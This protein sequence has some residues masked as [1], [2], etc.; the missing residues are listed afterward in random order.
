MFVESFQGQYKD[1]T[2]GTCDFRMVSA[3]FLILRMLILAS[4]LPHH[5]IDEHPSIKGQCILFMTATGFYAI[6]K[7]YKSNLRNIADILILVLLAIA[8]LILLDATHNS[9]NIN[10]FTASVLLT[11]LL[12]GVPHMVLMFYICYML[13]KKAGITQ[14]LQKKHISLKRCL[15]A[16]KYTSQAE[17]DGEAESYIPP[18][19][20]LINPVEYEP[21]LPT[22][23]QHTVA[24]PTECKQSVNENSRV[25]TPVYTYA[26]FN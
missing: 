3:L 17:T 8:S 7:P 6:A 24:E 2:D 15:Q 11:S 22:T 9:A 12:L 10:V 20:R 19:D 1:G 26:S 18:P 5:K 13:A 21:L 25:L 14:W 4:F 23:G 16:I